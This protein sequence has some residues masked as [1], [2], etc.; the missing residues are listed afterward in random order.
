MDLVLEQAAKVLQQTAKE[1]LVCK[2]RACASCKL[3]KDKQASTGAMVCSWC[4]TWRNDC[5]ARFLL[6]Q[7]NPR[8]HLAVI[9]AK[10]KSSKE[11]RATMN[12]IRA[13]K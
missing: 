4:E 7:R 6:R 8:A 2:D 11:L 10:R 3:E 9:D 1:W 12:A 13:A 5:E